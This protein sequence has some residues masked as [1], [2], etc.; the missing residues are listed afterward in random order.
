MVETF[1]PD[2]SKSIFTAIMQQRWLWREEAIMIILLDNNN[3][4]GSSSS[5][6]RTINQ[7]REFRFYDEATFRDIA[8]IAD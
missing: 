4:Y 2:N 3:G 1:F 8:L 6:F 5:F 7:T